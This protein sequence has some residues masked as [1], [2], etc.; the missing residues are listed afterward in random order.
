VFLA[1]GHTERDNSAVPS[2]GDLVP[3]AIRY[4]PL[5]LNSDGGDRASS[6]AVREDHSAV[7]QFQYDEIRAATRLRCVIVQ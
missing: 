2:G 1:S 7:Y 5:C 4:R 6:T 3:F